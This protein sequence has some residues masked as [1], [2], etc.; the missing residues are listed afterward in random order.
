MKQFFFMLLLL[1]AIF[2]G[3]NEDVTPPIPVIKEYQLTVVDKADVPVSKVAVNMFMSQKPEFLVTSKNTDIFGKVHFL[4]LKPGK[5]SLTALMGEKEILRT[6]A[7]VGDDNAQNIATLKTDYEVSMSDYKVIIK[8]D[9]GKAIAERK[10]D[11]LTKEEQIVYKSG[12]TDENGELV[13]AKVPLDDYLLKVYDEANEAV[14][15]T[16]TIS[17]VEDMTRNTSNVEI[18]KLIHYSDIVITGALIDPKGSDSPKPGSASGGGYKHIGGYEYIQLLALKDINFDETPYCVIT[19]MN[20]TN[21]TDKTYP[22]AL[23]GWVESKGRGTKTTY[24]MDITSG[25]VKKGQFFYVGGLSGIIA[26]YYDD[27]GSPA[28][29]KS[30]WWGFDF[31]NKRGSSDNGAAK[32][33]SGIFNNLNSDKKTNVPDGIAVFKGTNI[34]KNTVPQ[35]VVFYGGESPIRKEDRYLIT[36]NDL[37]RT[38]DSKGNPQPYFGDGTNTWFAKQGYNDDGCYIMMGGQVSATEWLKPRDGKLYKLNVKAGPESV[39]VND[40]E[41]GEG[42]TVFVDK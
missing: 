42:V 21:P 24:Q 18:I 23:D 33:S 39:S 35:D 15:Q 34:D 16:E 32:G 10:V 36:D 25:S 26:S 19:G 22:A 14:V 5:Y 41:S 12:M 8:S 6:E 1:G 31:Y 4:N 28:V 27:W 29:E 20:A 2:T 13:F 11:L 37:Y 17:V 7:V 3:C 38:V 30:R 40:I 9:R